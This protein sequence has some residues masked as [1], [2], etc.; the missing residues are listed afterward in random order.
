MRFNLFKLSLIFIISNSCLAQNFPVGM[1]YNNKP[2][3]PLCF[4]HEDSLNTTIDLK[5]CGIEAN[6]TII[7]T[8]N[9]YF[10][11]FTG[12]DYRW[13]DKED[14]TLTS[15]NY[16]YYKAF[17][18]INGQSIIYLLTSGGGSGRFSSL[19]LVKRNG[20]KL[21]TKFLQGGDRCNGGIEKVEVKDDKLIYEVNITPYDMVSITTT[22]LKIEELVSCSICCT[23]VAVYER[24]LKNI[25][26]KKLIAVKLT[27]PNIDR[28]KGI[29]ACFNQLVN[30][31]HNRGN[32]TLSPVGLDRFVS[33]LQADCK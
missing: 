10:S 8:N 16:A 27:N 9:N 13:M 29:Q 12:F 3:D 19:L 4:D 17:P 24:N 2:I 33:T 14:H 7:N 23:G 26:K 21:K 30:Q 28:A 1:I 18:G 15:Q 11:G 20:D 6:E 22:G 31:Y 32:T 5:K 25:K